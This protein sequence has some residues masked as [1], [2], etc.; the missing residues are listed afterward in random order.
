M[1]KIIEKKLWPDYFDIDRTAP[2]DSKLADFD[3]EPGDQIR[4]REWDP[5]T[6]KYTGREYTRTVG[7]VIRQESPTRYW[8]T[9]QLEKHG[10]YL[11]RWL[12]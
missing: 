4:F 10:M 7:A 8:T 12:D 5:T 2:M 1:R 3:L 9:E 11:I 6:K